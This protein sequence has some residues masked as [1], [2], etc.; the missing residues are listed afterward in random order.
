MKWDT[1]H[2]QAG[3]FLC[4]MG[5]ILPSMW[6]DF[7]RLHMSFQCVSGYTIQIHMT[8]VMERRLSRYLVLPSTVSKTSLQDSR[9]LM[10][11]PRLTFLQ[12]NSAFN[13]WMVSCKT[14]IS[15]VLTHKRYNS[16]A[17]SHRYKWLDSWHHYNT[18]NIPLRV[19]ITLHWD[20]LR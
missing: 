6:K 4:I 8:R 1:D 16:L 14:E 20:T 3:Y 13:I 7:V 11:R 15:P 5:N 9:I 17:L 12:N 18:L 19:W 2:Q 10:T